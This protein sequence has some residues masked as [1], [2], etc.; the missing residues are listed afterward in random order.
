MELVGY[1]SIV[2]AGSWN[3]RILT[4]EWFYSQFPDLPPKKDIQ[5]EMELSSG[6]VKFEIENIEIKTEPTKLI[7]F[8]KKTEERTYGLAE[9]LA[10]G[11]TERLLHTP[12]LGVGH[13][14][15]YSINEKEKFMIFR[16]DMLDSDI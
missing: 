1:P 16:D 5:I 6:F 10:A 2:I 13:N 3:R 12:F 9:D 7:L 11:I 8:A 14:L 15:D 4:P